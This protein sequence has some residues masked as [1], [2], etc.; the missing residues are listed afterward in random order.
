MSSWQ[1]FRWPIVIGMLTTIG[2]ISGLV[3]EG[4]GDVIAALGLFIPVAV[5]VWFC[6]S[7]RAPPMS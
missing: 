2:L 5:V 7:R 1:I 3:S 4:W 6:V